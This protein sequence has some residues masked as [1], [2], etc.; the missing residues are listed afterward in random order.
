MSYS[1]EYTVTIE[2][3]M[4]LI[5]DAG[6]LGNLGATF[7]IINEYMG[8]T[9]AKTGLYK[10]RGVT[11]EDFMDTLI[12]YLTLTHADGS[13]DTHILPLTV[14]KNDTSKDYRCIR[15]HHALEK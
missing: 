15:N 13:I 7:G 1:Y 6:T 12:F 9:S 4:V 3:D 2:G 11:A 14:K 8:I 5:L 10:D